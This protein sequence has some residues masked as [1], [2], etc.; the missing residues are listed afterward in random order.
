MS[1]S[2]GEPPLPA[3]RPTLVNVATGEM[4]PATTDNIP[5]VVQAARD[6]KRRIDDVIRAATEVLREEAAIRGTK[7]FHTKHGTVELSGG[8]TV[9]YDPVDLAEAL[10]EAGCPEDRVGEAVEETISYRVN[11]SVLRQLVGAN[12]AYR[13]A[14][15]RA[16]REV[17]NAWRCSVRAKP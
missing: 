5:V 12:P 10:R 13:E 14:A 4:L 11:R 17:E 7:T 15:V 8:P 3:A 9:E 1:R 6:M 16:E 2:L